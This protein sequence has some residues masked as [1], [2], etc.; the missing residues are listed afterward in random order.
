M[1]RLTAILLGLAALASPALAQ[2]WESRTVD[3][4]S[5]LFGTAR[6]EGAGVFFSCT[7]PSP[8]GVPLMETGSHES[9]RN[10]P[11]EM[12]VQVSDSLFEWTDPYR[13]DNVVIGI[14]N[15]GYQLPPIHLDELVGSGVYLSMTDQ[16]VL[17]LPDAQGLVFATGQGPVHEWTTDGLGDALRTALGYCANRWIAMGH[18]APA[19][20]TQ[21]LAGAMPST[22]SPA[23]AQPATPSDLPPI[24]AQRVSQACG[25][26]GYTFDHGLGL[27]QADFDGDGLMDYIFSGYGLRCYQGLNPYCGASNCTVDVLLSSRGYS[28]VDAWIGGGFTLGTAPDGRPG[29][30]RFGNN[31]RPLEVW[32]GSGFAPVQ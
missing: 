12:T 1:F 19:G 26:A 28:D 17:A 24:I 4:G 11:F 15:V 2:S 18:P 3:N 14:G 8:A 31:A 32:T 10:D 23:P 30:Y 20:L 5:L 27:G 21:M 13:Q 9:H 22:P 29:F 25:S 6:L 16:L 7:A